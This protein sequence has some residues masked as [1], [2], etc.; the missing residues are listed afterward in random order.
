[1]DYNALTVAISY[2]VIGWAVGWFSLSLWQ[3]FKKAWN[4]TK[5]QITK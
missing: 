1:M 2:F 3:A 5:K 4:S